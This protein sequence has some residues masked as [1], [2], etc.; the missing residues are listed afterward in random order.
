M[1]LDFDATQEEI[2][3]FLAEAKE[4]IETLEEG[5][6]SLEQEQG[7]IDAELL[8]SIFRAAHTLKGSSAALG[9]VDMAKLTHEMENS[10]IACP[11][12]KDR[13][14]VDSSWEFILEPVLARRLLACP[15]YF[16]PSV[17]FRTFVPFAVVGNVRTITGE[18]AV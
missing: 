2:Q 17:Y 5:I 4:Q 18:V 13:C 10:G 11:P 15:C 8:Q 6:M 14:Y 16:S 12:N 9:H 3:I 1:A 7:D